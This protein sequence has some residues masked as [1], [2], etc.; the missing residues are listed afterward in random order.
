MRSC[1]ILLSILSA[2]ALATACAKQ[3][4]T[5]EGAPSAEPASR[6]AAP[7]NAEAAATAAARADVV[8]GQPRIGG[9]LAR[10]GD[11]GV[12]VVMHR[13]GLVEAMVTDS[14]SAEL[15]TGVKLALTGGLRGG[16]RESIALAFS[17]ARSRFTGEAR[18]G[19]E[20]A[21]GPLDVLLEVGGKKAE[22]RLEFAPALEAP[23]LG[24]HVLALGTY[25]AEVL[26]NRAGTVHAFLVDA[27]GADVQGGVTLQATVRSLAGGS[28]H[29]ALTF[30]PALASFTG[31]AKAGVELAPGP[32]TLTLEASGKQLVGAL[33]SAAFHV[34][35]A[36][37]GH[38]LALGSYAVELVG[39]GETARAFVFDAS[40][41]AVGGA[42]IGLELGIGLEGARKL[43]FAWDAP[44]ASY[45]LQGDA[46]IAAAPLML[47]L[48]AAGKSFIGGVAS[49]KTAGQLS[50]KRAAH[51]SGSA[52]AAGALRGRAPE[53]DIRAPRVAA[54]AGVKAAADAAAN[55]RLSAKA[56]VTPPKVSLQAP[57]VGVSVNKSATSGAK[58]G[59]A[60]KASGSF[61]FGTK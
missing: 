27:A 53:V 34:D 26:L 19:V 9:S 7:A 22:G 11:Y 28:E 1:R 32:L 51:L 21:S 20:L 43:A 54:G 50:S 39:S 60:A 31:R 42:D 48:T 8:L 35:A 29:V 58:A 18:A 17:P 37:G 52:T 25:G 3:E 6:A 41:K 12:E 13:A 2:A 33:A 4:T 24:G 49:L 55:A 40:G 38:V 23:R 5:N 59:N 10:V 36:H 30:E 14:Q 56:A 61:S 57:K 45:R 47:T 46:D 16:S 15:S 44:S